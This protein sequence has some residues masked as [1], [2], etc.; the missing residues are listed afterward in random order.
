M[1]IEPSTDR[2]RASGSLDLRERKRTRTRLMIQT[3]ALRLFDEKSYAQTTVEEI[4]DAAAISPRTFFRYFPAK[5][6]VVM[7]DEY[8]AVA[9]DLLEARPDD[10]PLVETFRAVIRESLGGLYR[11][12]PERLLSRVRLMATVPELRSRFLDAQTH[13]VEQLAPLLARKRGA[14]ADELQLRV[15]GSAVLAAVGVALDL[16][17]KDDGKGDLLALLDRA[18]DSLAEGMSDVQSSARAGAKPAKRRR[19]RR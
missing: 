6:D 15:I 2:S 3:E 1:A 16:W 10:E 12:D 7:W 4:A 17:Q 13:G 19:S 14:R 18:I 9:H 8:D 11:R 5:D